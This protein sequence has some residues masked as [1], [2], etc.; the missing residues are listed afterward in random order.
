MLSNFI[1]ASFRKPLVAIV[2]AMAG[3]V[4]GTVWMRELPRDVFP[5]LSAPCSTSS[6]RTRR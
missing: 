3:A 6:S 2:L 4:I 5:D 1:T